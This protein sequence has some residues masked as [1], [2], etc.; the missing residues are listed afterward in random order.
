MRSPGPSVAT[1]VSACEGP[2]EGRM[3]I[4]IAGGGDGGEAAA[5]GRVN[6]PHPRSRRGG[7]TEAGGGGR[8]CK[9]S[10]GGSDCGGEDEV[11][12][13]RLRVESTG[14]DVAGGTYEEVLGKRRASQAL[15]IQR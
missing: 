2:G 11:E 6:G 12:R 14:A 1:G 8:C 9:R 4:S 15:N 3:S 10:G 5:E 13:D 7:G